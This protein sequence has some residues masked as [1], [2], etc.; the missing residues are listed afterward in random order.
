MSLRFVDQYAVVDALSPRTPSSSTPDIVSLKNVV[1]FTAVIKVKNATTVTGSAITLKQSTSVA[2]GSEKALSFTKAFRNID[3]AAADGLT[4]FTVS[5]DT[6][7]TDSTDS[8]NLVYVIEVDPA[9]LDTNN[10]FD[11]LR[12]GTGNA[13]AAVLDVTYYL[14]L[15]SHAG[16]SQPSAIID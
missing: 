3:T 4:E 1:W 2:A 6:F 14:K 10:G 5:S 12:V 15:R 8:K 9:S 16:A 11:C 7:T 13:T